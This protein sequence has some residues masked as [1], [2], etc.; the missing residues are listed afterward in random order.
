MAAHSHKEPECVDHSYWMN[1][2]TMKTAMHHGIKCRN[3][4][5]LWVL[6]SALYNKV[7]T[8]RTRLQNGG[9]LNNGT[10]Y[11]TTICVLDRTCVLV[12]LW[13][14]ISRSPSTV[15]IQSLHLAKYS[16]NARMCSCSTHFIED[17]SG[18]D[19]CGLGQPN[20]PECI[21]RTNQLLR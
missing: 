6:S 16:P 5:A 18:G 9:A 3:D 20:I 12:D 2:M 11:G 19:L 14:V 1:L 10:L 15:P 13:N 17:A 4:G 21:S 8:F 7:H